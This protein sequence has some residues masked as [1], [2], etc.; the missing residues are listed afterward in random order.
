VLYT[1]HAQTSEKCVCVT[2]VTCFS[3]TYVAILIYIFDTHW[4]LKTWKAF[5]LVKI[6]VVLNTLSELASKKKKETL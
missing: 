6:W 2:H 5:L 3:C 1:P 4:V